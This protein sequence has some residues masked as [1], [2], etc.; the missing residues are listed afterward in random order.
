M[1][2]REPAVQSDRNEAG[3]PSRP[4]A[5]R[6][7]PGVVLVAAM[8]LA[9]FVVPA[10]VPEAMIGGVLGV[11]LGGLG[12]LLWWAF[13]S[14]ARPAA[15]FGAVLLLV[16]ALAL[17]P[18]VLH[19]SIATGMEGMMFALYALP[20][21]CLVLVGWALGSRN[22]SAGARRATLVALVVLASGVWALVRTG[23]FTGDLDHDF[24]WRWAETPEERLLAQAADERM[25]VPEDAPIVEGEAA[26]PG[27]RGPGRDGVVRGVSIDIDWAASPPVLLWR[28]PV[29]PGWS[30]CAVSG[31]R[32][33]TQEQRGEDE[34]VACYELTTGEP[35]WRHLDATR[36]WESNAGA[37]PRGTPTLSA[38]LVFTLGATGS[39]NALDAGDGTVLWS[40]NAADDTETATPGWGFSGSPLVTGDLVV[41]AAA[42]SL[43][44]YDRATG[45]VRWTGPTSDAGYSS[46]Q[47][48]TL[49]GV[50]QIL[51]LNGD[52]VTGIAP[53]DG[54]SLWTHAWEGEPIVQPALTAEGDLLINA[55]DQSGVRRL[56][57]TREPGEPGGWTVVERW[58]SIRMKPFYAD[59][60]VHA[61]HAYGLDGG[62]LACIDLA[63]GKRRW[64]GG[65]YGSGQLVLLADQE[66]LLVLTEA[67]EVVLVRALPDAFTELARI[68][69]IE[70]KTWNHPVLVGDVLVVRNA[71]EMA[72]FRLALVG[73]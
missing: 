54:A 28:R 8:W 4:P 22:L 19:E 43:I 33:Y 34:V 30:S 35:I 71:E 6:L 29:G 2:T 26:W 1:S 7:W 72:A 44:A 14:R 61:G 11:F 23:G 70:S 38:G 10:I 40:R 65:R 17:T 56:G 13:F 21:L 20:G 42:G 68:E 27:F 57:I 39:V 60:V 3:N 47:L 58:T 69:A 51:L 37:G 9:R 5:L 73:E 45:A 64:K 18:L 62:I 53:E 41:V 15:R 63:D 12:V 16:A 32:L 49:G 50:E 48:A 59:F 52:G 55:G 31:D 67:G 46:P 66:L 36:F 24:A 25:V